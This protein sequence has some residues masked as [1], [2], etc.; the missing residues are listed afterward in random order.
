[1]NEI[2]DHRLVI[3]DEDQLIYPPNGGAPRLISHGTARAQIG[4]WRPGFLR[5]GAPLVFVTAFKLLD[6]LLEWVLA[7]NGHA[8]THRFKDKIKTLQTPVCFPP[9]V[10]TRPWLR[11]RLVA[12]YEALEPLRG[13][14]IHGRHFSTSNGELLVSSSKGGVVGATV[15]ISATDLRNL[16]LVVVSLLRY[17]EGPWTMDL[18]REKRIRR[19]LDELAHLHGLMPLGQLPPAFLT[20]RVYVHDNDSIGWDIESIRQDVTAKRADQ[21]VIFDLRIIAVSRDGASLAEYLIPWDQLEIESSKPSKTCAELSRFAVVPR[22]D[23]DVVAIAGEMG[24]R[25]GPSDAN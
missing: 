20:V 22:A 14:I 10:E 13:T 24:L 3:D 16:A 6:M 15:T 23:L 21:D 19:A 25:S 7:K 18:L 9:I 4:D 1:M 12:L 2:V 17:L 11:E 8:S 5:A